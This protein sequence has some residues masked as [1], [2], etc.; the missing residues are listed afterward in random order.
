[1]AHIKK[2][3]KAV[4][5]EPIILT[6]E[7]RI[8]QFNELLETISSVSDKKKILWKNIYEFA[9]DD[10][11]NA[12]ALFT[13]LQTFVHANINNHAIHG[14]TLAK[15]LEQMG[16]ATERLLKLAELVAAGQSKEKEP[17]MTEDDFYKRIGA[18]KF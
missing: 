3:E 1:M 13:D 16:K 2:V 14:Q 12:Y 4:K 9:I 10:R 18:G 5:A 8:K 7:E 11:R 6:D 15:Y 17:E